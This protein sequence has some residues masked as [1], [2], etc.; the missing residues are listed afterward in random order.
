MF[1]EIQW[2]DCVIICTAHTK[3]D[4]WY[5][6]IPCGCEQGNSHVIKVL[7]K[8]QNSCQNLYAQFLILLKSR[9]A[10]NVLYLG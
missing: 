3:H 10:T 6:F 2:K 8:F 4:D 9:L 7:Y 1:E 5:Y